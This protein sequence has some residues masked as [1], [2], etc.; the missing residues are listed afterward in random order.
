MFIVN[1]LSRLSHPTPENNAFGS[2]ILR[3][4]STSPVG[5]VR[6]FTD[7]AIGVKQS[8]IGMIA[9]DMQG[10]VLA[11]GNRT[12]PIMTNNEAEYMGLLLA[13]ELAPRL[14]ETDVEIHM[15]SEVVIYQMSGRFAVNSAALKVLHRQAC[16]KA[17]GLLRLHY[18]HI[19][20]EQNRLADALAADAVLGH[21]W[22]FNLPTAHP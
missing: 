2:N 15:D 21:M 10:N 7:G 5:K 14:R 17:R 3:V 12:L 22:S 18:V 9:Q 8:G 1:R 13:L 19:P 6:V 11:F 16:A 4:S 20:R